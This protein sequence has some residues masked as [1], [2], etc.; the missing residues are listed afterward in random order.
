[1]GAVDIATLQ[2]S[3]RGEAVSLLLKLVWIWQET[4][5]VTEI[6]VLVTTRKTTQVVQ[7][8]LLVYFPFSILFEGIR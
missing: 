6:A 3:S 1:M 5:G 7:Q 2:S 4:L 8:N